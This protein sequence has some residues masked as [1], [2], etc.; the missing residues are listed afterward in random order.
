[1]STK[2]SDAARYSPAS[3]VTLLKTT[4]GEHTRGM[5]RLKVVYR[6]L[7][8]PFH[9]LLA[10]IP[11]GASVFDL[12]CGAGAFLRLV[13][14]TRSPVSLGGIEIS[15][16]LIDNAR[17]LLSHWPGKQRLES[18]DG[19]TI[20]DWIVQ[21]DYV[22]LIDVL[23]HIP[24]IRQESFLTMLHAKMKP[25][26]KLILKDIDAGRRILVLFNKL[27]D[28]VVAREIGHELS[29]QHVHALAASIGFETC[30]PHMTRM[31][32]YPHFTLICEKSAQ[33]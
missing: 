29:A 7:I 15:S 11:Q 27:H 33:A 9:E 6:P 31:W 3:L 21:Y 22:T 30:P 12:G 13:A 18:Y 19:G 16:T 26:S 4:Q 14:E 17:E 25:G 23:H 8:C 28:F 20:P 32:V 24:A 1:M 10:L 5:I 2:P